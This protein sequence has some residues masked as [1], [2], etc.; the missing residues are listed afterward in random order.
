[1]AHLQ[2]TRELD[3]TR[4][5]E[6]DTIVIFFVGAHSNLSMYGRFAVLV[7]GEPDVL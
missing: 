1:M 7:A 6:L 5:D 3:A 2:C 4:S